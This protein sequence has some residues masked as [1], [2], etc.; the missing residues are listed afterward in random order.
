MHKSPCHNK[1]CLPRSRAARAEVS[2][3]SRWLIGYGYGNGYFN[4]LGLMTGMVI[5][6]RLLIWATNENEMHQEKFDILYCIDVFVPFLQLRSEISEIK[7]ESKLLF[8]YLIFHRAVGY[9][10][11]A[12][13]LAGIAGW[14]K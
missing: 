3:Y 8:W 1:M 9:L 4:A 12:F 10:L 5:A 6:A 14:T 2:S 11:G 7:T 13:V